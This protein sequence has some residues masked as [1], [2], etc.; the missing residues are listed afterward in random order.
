MFQIPRKKRQRQLF[1]AA[2]FTVI[3][4][5]VVGV[6]F[7]VRGVKQG[8]DDLAPKHERV[9]NK[10]IQ[11]K[12][13]LVEKNLAPLYG[14][15][16]EDQKYI[17]FTGEDFKNLYDNYKYEYVNSIDATPEIT[18]D[19]PADLRIRSL[20]ESRGYKLRPQ[21]TET[22]LKSTLGQN[23]NQMQKMIFYD[24]KLQGTKL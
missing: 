1:F 8:L 9:R 4:I 14:V 16:V 21:A 17:Q 12:Q 11:D 13:D 24:Y 23:Y 6:F 2:I 20:A 10:K 22:Y 7:A 19:E 3:I 5:V 18:G 15:V